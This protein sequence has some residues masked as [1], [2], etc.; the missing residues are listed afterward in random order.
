VKV[1]LFIAIALL[2]QFV[3]ASV[4]TSAV[5]DQ[6]SNIVRWN[7]KAAM[8]HINLLLRWTPR[9]IGTVGHADTVEYITQQL[10]SSPGVTIER[11]EWIGSRGDGATLH[12]INVIGR[13]H[14]ERRRRIILATHFD[15]IVSAYKDPDSRLRADP[16]PG[17]NNSASGVAV[18][19][20]TL[21][22]LRRWIDGT[23]GVDFVFLDGEE[24]PYSLGE[25]DPKW[26]PLGSPHFAD[27]LQSLYPTQL[28]EVAIVYDMVCKKDL[29]LYPEA[30]S[31]QSGGGE[32]RRLWDIGKK[33]AP[34][35]FK[36]GPTIGPIGDDQMALAAKGIP[37]ILVIDFDYSPWFNTTKDT[38]D[39]CSITSLEAVGRTTVLYILNKAASGSSESGR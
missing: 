21:H 4:G 5:A 10:S 18:L 17:A 14:P 28:P 15:S 20:E 24:G 29:R 11:Q 30:L 37:S 3:A 27:K 9:S 31:I 36:D 26:Y 8:T 32:F 35:V 33:T 16:M 38:A 2:T 22:S 23:V 6:A 25:G 39:K 34:G 12:L 13:F 19:L 7:G 1:K